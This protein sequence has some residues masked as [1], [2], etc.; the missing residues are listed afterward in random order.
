MKRRRSFSTLTQIQTTN[1][2]RSAWFAAMLGFT[3]SACAPGGESSESSPALPMA[4]Q[5]YNSKP[6]T[7]EPAD[8]VVSQIAKVLPVDGEGGDRFGFSTAVAE[9]VAVF[10]APWDDDKGTYAG[11]AYVFEYDGSAWVEKTK[12]LA[13]DGESG[14]FFGYS[15]AA[16]RDTIVVGARYEDKNGDDAGAAYVFVRKNGQWKQQAKLVASGGNDYDWFGQAVAIEGDTIVVGAPNHADGMVLDVGAAYVFGRTFGKWSERA[17][18]KPADAAS[19]I[20]FGRSVAIDGGRVM[21]GAFRGYKNGVETGAA[22]L[23][24]QQ[25]GQWT[26]QAKLVPSNGMDGD[27]FGEAIA[28]EGDKALMGAPFRDSAGQ[29]SGGAYVFRNTN[30]NTWV[31]EQFVLPP[32]LSADDR[33]GSAVTISS[34]VMSVGAVFGNG[35]AVSSGVAHMVEDVAGQWKTTAKVTAPDT[36]LWEYFSSS[37]SLRGQTLWVG[38][39]WDNDQGEWSGSAYVFRTNDPVALG[40]PCGTGMDCVSGFCADGVCCDSACGNGEVDCQACSVAAGASVDGECGLVNA[41]APCRNSTGECDPAETCDGMNTTCPADV[42]EAQGTPCSMGTCQIGVCTQPSGTGGS[43]GM[44]GTGGMA[45]MGGTGGVPVTGGAGGAGGTGGMG[46]SMTSTGQGGM[47][48]QATVGGAGGAVGGAGNGGTAGAPPNGGSAGK[49]DEPGD[50]GGCGCRV[51]H[52]NST[53][54]GWMVALSAIGVLMSAR[55][56]KMKPFSR[57]DLRS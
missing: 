21:V 42:V 5:G 52:T 45:G 16:D 19:G 32:A 38:C 4:T 22:Y 44:A 11:S 28:L 43:G 46:G 1:L 6:A 53:S 34:N 39:G 13:S 25:T 55:R 3:I 7:A 54:S 37:L 26:E 41:G 40:Q 20:G 9:N 12:L 31:E 23:F 15:V 14:E 18:L 48:G 36:A 57:S 27:W 24:S 35:A 33:F 8:L 30:G 29:D 56:R 47:G 10:G 2:N 50:S 17:I 51:D 49:V